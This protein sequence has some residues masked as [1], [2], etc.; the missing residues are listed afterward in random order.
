MGKLGQ[1]MKCGSLAV[2]MCLAASA[3]PAEDKKDAN[4]L[5]PF[6]RLVGGQWIGQ[7]KHGPDDDFR[8]RVIYTWGL[9]HK[10]I[11]ISSF[12]KSKEG[13]KLVYESFI[14]Y[15]PGKKTIVF[16]SV[17]ESGSIFDGT[18]EFK[19]DEFLCEFDS[20]AGD[21]KSTFRQ[22]IKFVDD[23]NTLWTVFAKKGDEWVKVIESKTHREPFP[24]ATK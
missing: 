14:N 1:F 20:L 11:K 23:D 2:L 7:G 12:L 10:V 4:P 16:T 13:E 6:S 21:K 9:N 5:D 15:H 18:M 22:T 8:T 19:G 17:N 3:A 24:A